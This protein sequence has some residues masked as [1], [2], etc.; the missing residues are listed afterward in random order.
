M[1]KSKGKNILEEPQEGPGE[2]GIQPS[3]NVLDLTDKRREQDGR[4]HREVTQDNKFSALEVE[5]SVEADQPMQTEDDKPMQN[6]PHV[7]IPNRVKLSTNEV[8]NVKVVEFLKANS[9]AIPPSPHLSNIATSIYSSLVHGLTSNGKEQSQH[10]Q[11][12]TLEN[13][14]SLVKEVNQDAATILSSRK[15]NTLSNSNS[16][17]S[18]SPTSGKH[19]EQ[20]MNLNSGSPGMI[21]PLPLVSL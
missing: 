10:A 20:L 12:T 17:A 16:Q 3:L 18:I 2:K 15:G 5:D 9:N 7:D 6:H 19:K 1:V 4:H 21:L 8:V 11:F 14:I 13:D